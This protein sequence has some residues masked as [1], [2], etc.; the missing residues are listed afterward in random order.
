MSIIF[1]Y[2]A[3][4]VFIHYIFHFIILMSVVYN[5][6]YIVESFFLYL[7]LLVFSLWGH[8]IA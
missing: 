2:L 4:P 8:M 3:W 7:M 1:P 5:M 6:Y